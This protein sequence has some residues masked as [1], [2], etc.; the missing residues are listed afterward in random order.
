MDPINTAP[1]PQVVA[2]FAPR[3]RLAPLPIHIVLKSKLL[4]H[5]FPLQIIYQN[6]RP[7]TKH[8]PNKTCSRLSDVVFLT[9]LAFCL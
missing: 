1:I 3:T 5:P 8:M 4:V 7:S 6:N 2:F 9:F